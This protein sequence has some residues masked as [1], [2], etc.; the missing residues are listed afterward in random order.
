MFSGTCRGLSNAVA[1]GT[2]SYACASGT[3]YESVDITTGG[4]DYE[5]T[6]CNTCA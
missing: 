1:G 2:G 6:I 4:A 5:L 3:S